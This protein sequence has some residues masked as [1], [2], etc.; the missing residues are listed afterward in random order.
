MKQAVL[1]VLGHPKAKEILGVVF[2]ALAVLLLA[3]LISFD[4]SDPSFFHYRGNPKGPVK[5]LAG[6][7]RRHRR[8]K[9][10]VRA[11]R[12][13]LLAALRPG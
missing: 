6:N 12:P 13:A 9:R 8:A 2:M 7:L 10:E 11:S 3:S 1:K 4:A 5:N